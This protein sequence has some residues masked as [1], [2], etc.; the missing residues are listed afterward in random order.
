MTVTISGPQYNT[1]NHQNG[2][3]G[4]KNQPRKFAIKLPHNLRLAQNK[5]YVGTIIAHKV[6]K[7]A[8]IHSVLKLAWARYG[9]VTILDLS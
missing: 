8:S 1:M 2:C 9:S 3:S 7:A 4:E 6:V 5:R